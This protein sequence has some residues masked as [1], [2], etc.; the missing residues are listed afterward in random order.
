MVVYCKGFWK[1][2]V[3]YSHPFHLEEPHQLIVYCQLTTEYQLFTYLVLTCLLGNDIRTPVLVRSAVT[4]VFSAGGNVVT[5]PFRPAGWDND[6]KISILYENMQSI[7]P[8]EYYT[9]VISRP[10]IKKVRCAV[11]FRGGEW[12]I[13]SAI[14]FIHL[15]RE[16]SLM[17]DLRFITVL[18]DNFCFLCRHDSIQNLSFTDLTDVPSMFI[19]IAN[20]MFTLLV[21]NSHF[22]PQ[23]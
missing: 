14:E 15:V 3:K 4:V 23:R 2:L 17:S 6:K 16:D 13:M 7:D 12:R 1:V 19:W 11:D 8:E 20:S 10:A 5:W 22:S 18:D 21:S 9:A